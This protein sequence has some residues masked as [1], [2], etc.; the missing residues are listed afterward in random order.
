MWSDVTRV[1]Q[2]KSSKMA[3]DHESRRKT[4]GSPCGYQLLEV[5]A[6]ALID[7]N[8]PTLS[9]L[10]WVRTASRSSSTGLIDQNK[11]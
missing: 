11:M 3:P 7:R 10:V 4:I 1:D 6:L 5:S 2:V 8:A 9:M